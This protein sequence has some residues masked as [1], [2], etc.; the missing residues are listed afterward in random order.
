MIDLNQMKKEIYLDQIKQL[1]LQEVQHEL[2]L[3]C[4]SVFAK[5]IKRM[6]IKEE[7]EEE[8]D[9]KHQQQASNQDEGHSGQGHP[10]EDQIRLDQNGELHFS[11]VRETPFAEELKAAFNDISLKDTPLTEVEDQKPIE[12]PDQRQEQRNAAVD[13]LQ[14]PSEQLEGINKEKPSNQDVEAKASPSSP[15]A[16]PVDRSDLTNESRDGA[17]TETGVIKSQ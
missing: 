4:E 1:I 17:L 16:A 15:P 10:A 13:Q 8:E 2:R 7:E 11:S 12:E 3:A 6:L 14:V 5:H 9:E